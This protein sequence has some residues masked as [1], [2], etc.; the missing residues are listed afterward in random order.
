MHI[1]TGVLQ[2]DVVQ[3]IAAI[4]GIDRRGVQV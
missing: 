3:V 4:A 2:P 1:P